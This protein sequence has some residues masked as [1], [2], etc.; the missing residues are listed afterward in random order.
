MGIGDNLILVDNQTEF[1]I[2]RN[3]KA[4]KEITNNFE[5]CRF[6][7]EKLKGYFVKGENDKLIP[8]EEYDKCCYLVDSRIYNNVYYPLDSFNECY[9]RDYYSLLYR[10]SFKIGAKSFHISYSDEEE[11]YKK[12]E[13]SHNIDAKVNHSI[14]EAE[15]NANIN[16]KNS[17]KEYN[18]TES[19]INI[20]MNKK[21]VSKEKF[22]AWLEEEK[23]NIKASDFQNIIGFCI[24]RYVEEGKVDKAEISRKDVKIE[25]N[26]NSHKQ[27]VKV[28]A[29]FK[30]APTFIKGKFNFDTEKSNSSKK[31]IAEMF[32]VKIVF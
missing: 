3:P 14:V 16:N 23:I 5:L 30:N 7:D 13:Y 2:K 19:D 6:G 12:E 1:N 27:F 28:S 29:G 4:T 18:K 26:I 9:K 31:K 22:D 10:I 32:K 20:Y 25:H 21:E 17:S 15:A 24:D 11:Y 8:L